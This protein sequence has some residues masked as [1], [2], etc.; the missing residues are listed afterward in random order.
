MADDFLEI[1]SKLVPTTYVKQGIQNLSSKKHQLNILLEQKK[2]P[3][4][5]YDDNL[6]EFIVHE[7]SSMDSNNF[8]SNCGVGEREG[9]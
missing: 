2:I 6:I 8:L 4:Q 9:R 5:G 3:K 1:A 7:F